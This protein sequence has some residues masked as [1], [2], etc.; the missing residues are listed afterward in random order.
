MNPNPDSNPNPCAPA[1]AKSASVAAF[2]QGVQW[3]VVGGAAGILLAL[4]LAGT[5]K[6]AVLLVCGALLG[7][8]LANGTL[9]FTSAYRAFLLRRE[10]RSL[11]AQLLMLAVATLLFAPVLAQG[12]VFGHP[13]SGALAP[14]GLQVVIGAFL[15]GIGM[16]VGDGC[17]SGTLNKAGAGVVRNVVALL[18]FCAGCF[19]ASLHM[20]VWATM[21]T[22]SLRSLAQPLGFPLAVAVQLAFIG[23]LALG[24]RRWAGR[25]PVLKPAS[26]GFG[27]RLLAGPWTLAIAALA[28]AVLNFVVLL[29]AGHPWAIT[30]GFTLWAAKVAMLFG[31]DPASAPFWTGAFQQQA[32]QKGVLGDITSLMDLGVMLGA[33]F[34]TGMAGKF[35]PSLRL[36]LKAYVAAILGGLLMG[37]GARVSYGCNIGAFFSGI[38]SLSLHGWVWIVF[39]IAGS[40]IGI[41]LRPRFG[42]SN[43]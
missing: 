3:R 21:P 22:L 12:S 30:W 26:G 25:Q 7:L 18:A 34:A 6:M 32:L 31:W 43:S 23:L 15:F 29:T 4:A 41:R 28:F 17:G 10:T 42:L 5:P 40:V 16:Q 8:T 35:A 24:L 9:G 11:H 38:A 1:P 2:W 39:A 13:V 19:V 27:R 36:P 14:L 20:H 37:Y 33:L